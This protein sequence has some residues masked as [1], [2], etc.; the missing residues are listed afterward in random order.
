MIDSH[1]HLDYCEPPDTELVAAASGVGVSRIVTVGTT[2]ASCRAALQATEDFPQVYAAIGRH[3]N[4]ST[5]FDDSST[6]LPFRAVHEGYT[7]AV[8]RFVVDVHLE[9]SSGQCSQIA[10]SQ[11]PPVVRV[12]P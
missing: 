2:S 6:T 5:G 4:E 12:C 1:T 3:P 9:Q 10:P 11:S 8:Y 7:P